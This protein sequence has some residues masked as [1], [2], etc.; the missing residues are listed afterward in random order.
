VWDIDRWVGGL[1]WR[2]VGGIDN[3]RRMYLIFGSLGI[4]AK[5]SGIRYQLDHGE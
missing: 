5:V 2:L 4:L 1:G 3:I